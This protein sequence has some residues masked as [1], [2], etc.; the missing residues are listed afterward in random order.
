M[1]LVI[2]IWLSEQSNAKGAEV[3]PEE[4]IEG[5]ECVCA[6]TGVLHVVLTTELPI[7]GELYTTVIE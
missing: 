4:E 3:G 7:R 1:Y 2:G 5:V 6:P